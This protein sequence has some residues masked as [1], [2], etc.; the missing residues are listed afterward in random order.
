MPKLLRK[1]LLKYLVSMTAGIAIMML[2]WFLLE[3][4]ID[5]DANAVTSVLSFPLGLMCVPFAQSIIYNSSGNLFVMD[6]YFYVAPY[7]NEQRKNLLKKYFRHQFLSG[8][9]LGAAWYICMFCFTASGAYMHPAKVMFGMV[10]QGCVY[11]QILFAGY[12]RPHLMLMI[13][14]LTTF[15]LGGCILAGIIKDPTLSLT[16]CI[17]MA[18]LG[19]ICVAAVLVIRFKYYEQMIDC[20]SRY[21]ASRKAGRGFSK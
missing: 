9:V 3:W 14:A 19:V 15:L 11:Y 8:C 21:E 20:Y 16:D 17:V 6:D 5:K 12:Y 18:V 10:V 4:L 1:S 7:S 13:M 2:T